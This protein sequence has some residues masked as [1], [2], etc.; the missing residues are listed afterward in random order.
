MA[1]VARRR[2]GRRIRLAITGAVAV[3]ALTVGTAAAMPTNQVDTQ[4]PRQTRPLHRQRP[5]TPSPGFLL[6]KGRFTIFDVPA[7]RVGTSPLGI[8]NRGQIIGSYSDPADG[9]RPLAL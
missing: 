6:D 8:N 1:W 3:T 7:A 2:A 9:G 5:R 4:A